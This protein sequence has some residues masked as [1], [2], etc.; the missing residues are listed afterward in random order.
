MDFWV[1][2]ETLIIRASG[3]SGYECSFEGQ[4]K[5]T[6]IVANVNQLKAKAVKDASGTISVMENPDLSHL[7]VDVRNTRNQLLKDSDW[8]QNRDCKLSD[9]AQ[10][11][12]ATYRQALRDLPASVTDPTNVTWPVP[13]Q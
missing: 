6:K 3:P 10:D 7:W 4:D 5:C 9:D 12:W 8:T 2:T 1:D 13:P 11:A